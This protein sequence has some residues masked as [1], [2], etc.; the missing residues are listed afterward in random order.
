MTNIK[1]VYSWERK[2]KKNSYFVTNPNDGIVK[3]EKYAK[4]YLKI[5]FLIWLIVNCNINLLLLKVLFYIYL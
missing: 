5:K 3:I 1:S 2:K 4:V